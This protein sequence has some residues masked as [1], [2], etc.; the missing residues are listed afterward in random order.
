MANPVP[1]DYTSADYPSIRADLLRRAEVLI[2]EWTSRSEADP[3]VVMAEL[4]SHTADLNNYAIDR[5]LQES[6]LPTASTLTAVLALSDML[7]YIPHGPVPSSGT[8]TLQTDDTAPDT[9]VPAGAQLVSEYVDS[10]DQ[11]L[12]FETTQTVVVPAAGGTVDVTVVEGRTTTRAEIGMSTGE[13]AQQFV[14]AHT[15]VL[16]GSV[17]IFIQGAHADLEWLYR[18][19]LTYSGPSDLVFTARPAAIG[20][21]I[22]QFGDGVTGAVPP[23]GARVYATYRTGAGGG[24]NLAAG[25]IGVLS[26]VIPGVQVATNASGVPLSTATGGG[27]DAESI[28]QIRRNASLSYSSFSRAVTTDDYGKIALTVPG[29][30]ASAAIAAVASS[31]NVYIAGPGRSVPAPELIQAVADQL[32]AAGSAGVTVTVGG[33][34]LVAINFGSVANPMRLTVAPQWRQDVVETQVTTTLTALVTNPDNGFG[35]R[36]SVG[37]VYAAL[38][39]IE[40]VTNITIPIMARVTDPQTTAADIVMTAWEL[41][42]VGTV[43]IDAVGGVV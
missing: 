28:D 30:T 10:L 4:M 18:P 21:I 33:P 36:V 26:T 40:G 11:S 16:D 8:V 29:V 34:S 41:P 5:L 12:V 31:V 24:G 23:L 6:Y 35:S 1:V 25:K 32:A 43:T 38:T 9:T 42:V 2:P 27:A 7:S 19:R 22:V 3:G 14:I 37:E 20:S 39:A 15:N 13:A 17:R